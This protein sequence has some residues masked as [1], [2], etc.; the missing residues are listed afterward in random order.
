MR[1]APIA[2]VIAFVVA[3]VAAVVVLAR[4]PMDIAAPSP[5]P[6]ASVAATASPS[7]NPSPTA[8]PT[9][10]PT[11]TPQGLYVSKRLAFALTLPTPWRKA[12]CGNFEPAQ[13]GLPIAEQFT[14]APVMEELI[15]HAGAANDR[16]D[17]RLEGNAEAL[18]PTQFVQRR[19][20]D[21][22]ITAV[23]FAG[24]PAV[25]VRTRTFGGDSIIYVFAEGDRM[26]SV[27]ALPKT[28]ALPDM[29]TMLAILRSFRLLSTAER[30]S[31]PDPTPF[32][33]R[34]PTT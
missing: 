15:G 20:S 6:S 32:T 10:S 22:T 4:P 8:S 28:S 30:Q 33:T 25:E 29:P 13:G 24:R 1:R 31:L 5:S 3:G 34:V 14:S 23:A 12:S 17:V 21:A 26:Y 19:Y 27:S 9:A 11:P 16:V 2:F 18:T 7:L